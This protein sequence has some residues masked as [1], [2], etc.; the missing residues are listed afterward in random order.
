MEFI[1]RLGLLLTALIFLSACST[2]T[3]LVK[4]TANIP[5]VTKA[6]KPPVKI[7]TMRF[8][9]TG[10]M[11]EVS[12]GR[13]NFHNIDAFSL[14]NPVTFTLTGGQSKQILINKMGANFFHS[15]TQLGVKYLKGKLYLDTGVNSI[16]PKENIPVIFNITPKW[17]SGQAYKMVNSHGI[18]DFR[19][20]TVVVKL[21]KQE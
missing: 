11:V 1:V 6:S 20:V 17:A 3:G 15:T 21:L 19:N 4:K 9:N 5:P 8:K 2:N 13:A 14:F 10:V 16:Y 18:A 12:A 7:V